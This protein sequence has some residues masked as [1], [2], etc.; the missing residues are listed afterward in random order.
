[1]AAQIDRYPASPYHHA[2]A[3]HLAKTQLHLDDPRP[4]GS[5]QGER[6]RSTKSLIVSIVIRK[7]AGCAHGIVALE[8]VVGLIASVRCLI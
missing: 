6:M 1:M 2:R 5:R 4:E 8:S 3:T 7:R